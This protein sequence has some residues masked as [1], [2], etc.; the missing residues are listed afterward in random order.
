MSSIPG[1][2]ARQFQAVLFTRAP[3]TPDFASSGAIALPG[4]P[5]ENAAWQALFAAMRAP[6]GEEFIGGE[7]RLT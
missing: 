5:T 3:S 6:G 1:A 4:E 7:V 2:T